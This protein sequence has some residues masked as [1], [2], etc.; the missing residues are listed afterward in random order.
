M[1]LFL[2]AGPDVIQALLDSFGTAACLVEKVDDELVVV[3]M[4]DRFRAYYGLPANLKRLPINV[5]SLSRA[6]GLPPEVVEPIAR[7][8]QTNTARCYDT[9]EIIHA[10]NEM[11]QADGS[12]RWSRNTI[13]PILRGN[14]V[15][16]LVVSVVDITE[17][18]QVQHELQENLTHL[19][20]QHVCIC[21]DCT[22]IC[23]DEG[24]WQTLEAF[25]AGE[26]GIQFSHGICPSCKGELTAC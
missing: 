12:E 18:M 3:A 19:I 11:P 10:E 22:R 8:M 1:N 14:K 26:R 16:S 6:T 5:E 4:N 9:G 2:E 21:R 15:V 17:T 20:G 13:A 7:R 25:M 24:E 23:N